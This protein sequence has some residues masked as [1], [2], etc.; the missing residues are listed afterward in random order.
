MQFFFLCCYIRKKAMLPNF[1]YLTYYILYFVIIEYWTL[2]CSIDIGILTAG[3]LGPLS[4]FSH[5]HLFCRGH[6]KKQEEKSEMD[7]TG[8]CN[9]ICLETHEAQDLPLHQPQLSVMEETEQYQDVVTFFFFFFF[10]TYIQ[11]NRVAQNLR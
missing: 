3:P 11:F 4:P 9:K 5:A 10:F 1:I 6:F 7:H 8:A 2:F